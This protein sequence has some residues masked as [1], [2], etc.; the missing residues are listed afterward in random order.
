MIQPQHTT[1]VNHSND[2]AKPPLSNRVQPIES[3][4]S[5]LTLVEFVRVFVKRR[6]S[7][8]EIQEKYL[9]ASAMLHLSGT[10]CTINFIMI[11]D[12]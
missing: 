2:K 1:R 7:S 9:Q 6:A 12:K 10:V 11:I 5:A 4:T 3:S 8:I